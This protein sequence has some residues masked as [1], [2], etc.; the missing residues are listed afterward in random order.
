MTPITATLHTPTLI[1]LDFRYDAATVETVN[2][3][4]GS[5]FDKAGKFWTVP[6]RS[7]GILAKT[8]GAALSVDFAVLDAKAQDDQNRVRIFVANCNAAGISL[9]MGAKRLPACPDRQ[10]HCGSRASP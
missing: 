4:R 3:I 1:R 9:G 8:F 10:P 7:L 2:M 6:V 5:A